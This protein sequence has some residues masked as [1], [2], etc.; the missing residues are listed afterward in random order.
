MSR[1]AA[2]LATT[3]VLVLLCA[4]CANGGEPVRTQS[5]QGTSP[6]T[7]AGAQGQA[8]ATPPPEE[9]QQQIKRDLDK[10]KDEGILDENGQ[11]KPGVDLRDYPGLG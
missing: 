7:A 3:L 9:E 5:S 1:K 6:Q 8:E 10:M 4:A 11:P 2:I